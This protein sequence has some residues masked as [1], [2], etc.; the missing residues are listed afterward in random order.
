MKNLCWMVIVSTALVFSSSKSLAQTSGILVFSVSGRGPT[1]I[2][3]AISYFRVRSG[4]SRWDERTVSN[5]EIDRFSLGPGDYELESYVR[6]CN[7]TCK[8]LDP[9]S[10]ICRAKLS[11][12]ASET[13]Y[14]VR[15]QTPRGNCTLAISTKAP[16]AA[17]NKLMPR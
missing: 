7:G 8:A 3:G 1:Y 6:P 15:N 11:I 10:D 14:A 4:N 2:E 17:T 5:S 13:L 12:Q 9:P 16:A